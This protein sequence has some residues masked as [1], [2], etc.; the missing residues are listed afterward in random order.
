MATALHQK[1]ADFQDVAPVFSLS[2]LR[3]KASRSESSFAIQVRQPRTS[4]AGMPDAGAVSAV[5]DIS[6]WDCSAFCEVAE[7][8]IHQ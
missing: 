8:T 2:R 4:F 7:V 3:F 1:E 6:S 5:L